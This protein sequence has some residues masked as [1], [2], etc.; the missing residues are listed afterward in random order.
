PRESMAE[1]QA[2]KREELLLVAGRFGGSGAA[3]ER[4]LDFLVQ[5]VAQVLAGLEV[6]HALGGDGDLLAGARIAAGARLAFLHREGGEAVPEVVRRGLFPQRKRPVPADRPWFWSQ[7]A[8][9]FSSFSSPSSARFLRAAPRM[10]PRLAPLSDE[11]KSAIAF[12][13]SSS[14]RALTD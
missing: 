8:T 3:T 12:F 14:S 2:L 4:A 1:R 6:G 10:S 13:S 7:K 5:A 11:P 9:Y